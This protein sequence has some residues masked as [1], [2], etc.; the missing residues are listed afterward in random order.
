MSSDE[1]LT[2]RMSVKNLSISL[3]E[4]IFGST[5]FVEEAVALVDLLVA[6]GDT[7]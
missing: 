2:N 6:K 3:R 5:Q 7:C 4:S 1:E